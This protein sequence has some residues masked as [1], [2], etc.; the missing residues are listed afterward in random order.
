MQTPCLAS[1]SSTDLQKLI[2]QHSK[3]TFS[4]G[5]QIQDSSDTGLS[6]YYISSGV[7]KVFHLDE[8]GAEVVL[9]LIGSG[10]LIINKISSF[11]G[12]YNL[13]IGA[14]TDATLIPVCRDALKDL[15]TSDISF[16]SDLL[17]L[18]SQ[19]LAIT[20]DRFRKDQ[21]DAMNKVL[22]TIA[23]VASKW[24]S[25]GRSVDF[26][27]EIGHQQCAILANVARET[28]TRTLI[29]LKE[30]NYLSTDDDGRMFLSDKTFRHLEKTYGN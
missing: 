9:F 8:Y 20:S 29:K 5:D 25:S 23:Y 12:F 14:L 10:E 2:R 4:S 19:Y 18:Q 11:S 28:F 30:R 1:L 16:L 26:I 27:K 22:A 7:L 17:R 3:I 15:L 13:S 21:S 24:S 6:C